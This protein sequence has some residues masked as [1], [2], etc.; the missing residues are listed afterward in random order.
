M[1]TVDGVFSLFYRVKWKGMLFMERNAAKY[2]IVFILMLWAPQIKFHAELGIGG[3]WSHVCLIDR[4]PCISQL[5]LVI[6]STLSRSLYMAHIQIFQLTMTDR[7]ALSIKLKSWLETF[8]Q[9]L[10][11]DTTNMFFYSLCSSFN[12]IGYTEKTNVTRCFSVHKHFCHCMLKI[13]L[14]VSNPPT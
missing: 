10:M 9:K 14:K 5:A 1:K 8:P 6:A 11:T 7:L 2:V 3:G 13:D 4:F 12:M